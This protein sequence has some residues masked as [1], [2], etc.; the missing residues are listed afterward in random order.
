MMPTGISGGP[1]APDFPPRAVFLSYAR[2]DVTA[3]QRIADALRAFGIEVWLDQS[4]LRGGEAWDASIRQ[5]IKSCV[6][7]LAIISANTQRRREGYFR[8]EWNLAVERINDMAH[9]APFL[10]PIVVDETSEGEAS[11]PDAFRRAQWIRLAHGVP[12]TQFVEQVRRLLAPPKP[13]PFRPAVDAES[14][15]ESVARGKR[16]GKAAS[17]RD[18]LIE[19]LLSGLRV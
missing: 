1:G 16:A 10:L 17:L 19:H 13:S 14:R 8:R 4:E 15:Q 2:E 12:S 7:F 6:L 5:Q 18:R 11:V 9:D 3:A